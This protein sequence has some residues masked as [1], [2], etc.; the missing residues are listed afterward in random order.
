MAKMP[1]LPP[2]GPLRDIHEWCPKCMGS[3]LLRLRYGGTYDEDEDTTTC[4]YCGGTGSIADYV[5][6]KL[7]PPGYE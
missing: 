5:A 6:N 3:G 2:H 7:N 1:D 4:W